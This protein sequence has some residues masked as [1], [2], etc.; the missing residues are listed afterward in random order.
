MPSP[1]GG[2]CGNIALKAHVDL[3]WHEGPNKQSVQVCVSKLFFHQKKIST[4]FS[5]I[6]LRLKH[7]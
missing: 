3:M 1:C 6:R 7:H 2:S 4:V 5:L